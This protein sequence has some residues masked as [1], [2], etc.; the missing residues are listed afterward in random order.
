MLTVLLLQP[1]ALLTY[2]C[3]L[4]MNKVNVEAAKD[5]ILV[6]AAVPVSLCYVVVLVSTCS[7]NSFEI[8]N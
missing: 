7:I 5:F 4:T 1:L 2:G 6:S 3:K 8:I